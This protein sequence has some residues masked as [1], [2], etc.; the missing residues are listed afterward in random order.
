MT[1]KIR[2][3]KEFGVRY[4]KIAPGQDAEEIE[5]VEEV[6]LRNEEK[7]ACKVHSATKELLIKLSKIPHLT[8]LTL[9]TNLPNPF[10]YLKEFPHLI[11]LE[12]TLHDHPVHPDLASL[13]QLEYLRISLEDKAI[14]FNLAIIKNM[15][16]LK[17]L[18]VYKI[19]P[20][21]IE[22][23]TDLPNLS[24]LRISP[25]GLTYQQL[26]VIGKIRNLKKLYVAECNGDE[27]A[28]I[29]QNKHDLEVLN[30]HGSQISN[31]GVALLKNLNKLKKIE[32][33]SGNITDH[34]L[35][36]LKDCSAL[37]SVQL[38]E[39]QLEGT[40]LLVMQNWPNLRSVDLS[41]NNISDIAQNL[42]TKTVE[43][44]QVRKFELDGNELD[45]EYVDFVKKFLEYKWNT[46]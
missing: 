8:I 14:P 25:K 24:S 41:C 10:P 19:L 1:E 18:S 44:D 21:S 13:T 20:K 32:F 42:I 46:D 43:M 34:G 16:A 2:L 38:S 39:N 7:I 17:C 33:Y 35:L 36:W 9:V 31:Q 6:E 29:I 4:Y 27:M 12:L 3:K 28:R 26:Q 5:N 40:T 45:E 15:N 22:C 37:E 23:L 11:D 30:L